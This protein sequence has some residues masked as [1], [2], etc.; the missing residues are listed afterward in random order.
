MWGVFL[1]ALRRGGKEERLVAGLIVASAYLTVLLVGPFA[2][3]FQHLE[4]PIL[5]VDALVFL[6]VLA[7]ALRSPKFWPL[8]LAAMQALTLFAHLAPYVPHILPWSYYNAAVMW[9]Y[10]TLIVLGFA[11][12]QHHRNKPHHTYLTP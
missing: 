8:W 3:R 7:I 11:V 4:M 6:F 12:F 2:K 10:P 5:M 1:Y 9:S